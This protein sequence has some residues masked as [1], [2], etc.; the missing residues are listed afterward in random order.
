M[1]QIILFSTLVV[2]SFETESQCEEASR[3]LHGTKYI[4]G[5]CWESYKYTLNSPLSRPDN[6]YLSLYDTGEPQ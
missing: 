5:G 6:L 3:Q 4:E 1:K 2:L